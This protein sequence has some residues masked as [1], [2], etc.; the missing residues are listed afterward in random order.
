[1]KYLIIIFFLVCNFTYAQDTLS[2]N[3]L[4]KQAN[5]FYQR[6]TDEG[7]SLALLNCQKV[8]ANPNKASASTLANAYF[9]QALIYSI[10]QKNKFALQ[11]YHQS[12]AIFKKHKIVSPASFEIY[13][14]L[15]NLCVII[16]E[17]DSAF[18]YYNLAEPTTPKTAKG[19]LYNAV[20]AL[21]Y[22]IGNYKQ[23]IN[24]LQKAVKVTQNKDNFS[25]VSLFNNNIADSY[26][27]LHCYDSALNY[28]NRALKN[29]KATD[30][31]IPIIYQNMGRCYLD[32]GNYLEGL[33]HFF[34]AKESYK[35]LKL[36][37]VILE[38]K[39]HYNIGNA[40]L[41]AGKTKEALENFNL[42]LKLQESKGIM[43]SLL[44]I[45][46][47]DVFSK[48]NDYRKALIEYQHAIIALYPKAEFGET[49]IY[50]NPAHIK[51]NLSD[52]YL[53]DALNRKAAAFYSLY[54]QT[55]KVSDLESS[56]ASYQLALQL[57]DYVRKSF[58]LE[59]M[60]LFFSSTAY[61][62]YESAVDVAFDLYKMTGNSMYRQRVFNI[63][64]QGKAT[65]LAEVL[66]DE[67]IKYNEIPDS[68]LQQEKAIKKQIVHLNNQLIDA[69]GEN[70]T[71]LHSKIRE[72]EIELGKL[73]NTFKKYPR[74]YEL[75]YATSVVEISQVQAAI[76]E[77]T[78]IIEYF[79]GQKS[80]YGIVITNNSCEVIKLSVDREK[81]LTLNTE[82]YNYSMRYNA[83]FHFALCKQ[84]F[85]PFKPFLEGIERVVFV[86]DGEL[87]YLS[88]DALVSEMEGKEA[89]KFLL[90]DYASSRA[91][92]VQFFM[93]GWRKQQPSSSFSF[94]AFA[95][96]LSTEVGDFSKLTHSAEE[97]APMLLEKSML[98]S[99]NQATKEA[100]IKM[101]PQ[102]N[103]LHLSTHAMAGKEPY[104]A[105]HN[106]ELLYAT[107]LYT[108]DFRK[109]EMVVLSACETGTG[110]LVNGEGVMSI[111]RGF[112]YGGCS[113]IVTTFW[114]ASELSTAKILTV[115]YKYLKAGYSRDK[116]LQ[117][118]K[119]DYL[120]SE[121]A[122]NPLWGFS[123][124]FYWSNLTV[125]G[126]IKPLYKYNKSTEINL[127]WAVVPVG[128][129]AMIVIGV[130]VKR[131]INSSRLKF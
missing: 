30:R 70:V 49:D 102:F 131:R 123:H 85:E 119:L 97:V 69:K 45:G 92:S 71:I 112:A 51:N 16:S 66:R 83:D 130:V 63:M 101:H 116:A 60:K 37:N 26:R 50:K 128:L 55:K 40:Y 11:N 121:V 57:V 118:A 73:I 87:N 125:I 129:V 13:R 41:R 81:L 36:S 24:Y 110:R 80:A 105:F 53:L 93:D 67:K 17:H 54:K 12:L 7:D 1:M 59:E 84:I 62:I 98:I 20:G 88:F 126:D 90:H 21:Y 6:A 33:K 52:L 58:D 107:E 46:K 38:G 95:P 108:L 56:F 122:M 72:Q 10:Q 9:T 65:V 82:M 5:E 79:Y 86:A 94:L 115:F 120:K 124:P 8:I 68:V 96:F 15:G 103:I 99:D 48:E 29:L 111:A 64:E 74:Y 31:N 22:K 89:K 42:S 117:L 2:M 27:K 47:G 32:E 19:S 28:Y 114:R 113:S 4:L 106:G 35:K 77:Q 127:L 76:D 39:L 25:S 18:Y 78:A 91:Y 100:F 75:K 61:P 44:L 3:F 43:T 104:I 14:A 23:A 109:T 34:R